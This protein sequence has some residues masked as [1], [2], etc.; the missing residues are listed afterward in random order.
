[1]RGEAGSAPPSLAGARIPAAC[2][3]QSRDEPRGGQEEEPMF[4]LVIAGGGLAAAR[5]IKSYH[6]SGGGGHIGC[7]RKRAICLTTA[8]PCRSPTYAVRGPMPLR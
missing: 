2:H 8:R 3:D 5:A 7:Y 6:E 1:V 4:D